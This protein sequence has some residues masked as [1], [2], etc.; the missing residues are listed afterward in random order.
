MRIEL[1]LS[2]DAGRS[3]WAEKARVAAL[4]ETFTTQGRKGALEKRE[5]TGVGAGVG[6][7]VGVEVGARGGAGAHEFEC[8]RMGIRASPSARTMRVQKRRGGWV[9]Q[10]VSHP[11]RPD[12]E[13]NM[14]HRLCDFLHD[15]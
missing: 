9:L 7:G 6:A 10:R 4:T 14:T 12:D 11:L 3:W 13:H 2:R 8:A 15:L 5:R 1:A